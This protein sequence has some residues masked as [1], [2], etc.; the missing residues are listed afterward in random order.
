MIVGLFGEV[1][2]DLR[3]LALSDESTEACDCMPTKKTR[4]RQKFARKSVRLIAHSR[5]STTCVAASKKKPVGV[6]ERT[7]ASH[8]Y[9]RRRQFS[10]SLHIRGRELSHRDIFLQSR[11]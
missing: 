10:S 5:Q 7:D 11:E 9:I 3:K 1:E 4:R 2:E 8:A 6:V